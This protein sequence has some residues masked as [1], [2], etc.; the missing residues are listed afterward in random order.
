MKKL[1]IGI[2][3]V[4]NVKAKNRLSQISHL[5]DNGVCITDP[6]KMANMFNKYFVNVGSNI[7]KSITRTRKSPL[8]FLRNRNVNSMF[9]APATPQELETIIH[10]LNTNKQLVHIVFLYFYLKSLAS[11]LHIHCQ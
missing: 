2:K 1:W 9:L 4:V 8:D 6:V 10:S 11:T 5:T 3:S 7:N